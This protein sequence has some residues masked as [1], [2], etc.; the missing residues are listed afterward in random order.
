MH[1][2]P[3]PS[4]ICSQ[5]WAMHNHQHQSRLTTQQLLASSPIPF[6]PNEPKP[7]T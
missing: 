6:N 3:Y 1:E 5:N 4:G 7:G 2:K